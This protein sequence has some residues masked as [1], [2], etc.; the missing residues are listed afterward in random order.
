MTPL[1]LIP[2]I[3]YLVTACATAE[4]FGRYTRTEEDVTDSIMGDAAVGALW[5][6]FWGVA[7]LC[8]TVVWISRILR[9][10]RGV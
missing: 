6:L 1:V 9:A 3:A 8:L 2:V 4:F 7:A 5:P 10:E